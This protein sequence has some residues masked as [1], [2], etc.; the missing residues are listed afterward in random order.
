MLSNNYIQ[1][2]HI[3]ETEA[4]EL[5][6]D[7]EQF[8]LTESDLEATWVNQ[9]RHFKELGKERAQEVN[10]VA[11]VELLQQLRDIESVIIMYLN[12]L[13]TGLSL[14][15]PWN[16]LIQHS[17]FKSPKI[18]SSYHPIPHTPR[19]YPKLVVA[20]LERSETMSCGRSS[21]WRV[22]WMYSGNGPLWTLSTRWPS[23]MTECKYLQALENLHLLVMKQLFEMHNLNML[24]TGY[25]MRTDIAQAL[26]RR[27]KAT[28]NTVNK[29]NKHVLTSYETCGTTFSLYHELMNR[30][31]KI[32]NKEKLFASTLEHLRG[33]LMLGPVLEYV[34]HRR[35]VN[36][37]LI[38]RI[39][40][41]Y[42]LPGLTWTPYYDESINT[43]HA[44]YPHNPSASEMHE[45]NTSPPTSLD[46]NAS[47]S[48]I[49]HSTPDD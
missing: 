11:Y 41:T 20:F 31:H 14:E 32:V 18:L 2:L 47:R 33:L 4:A 7:L 46:H 5:A 44:T 19:G 22:R 17:A 13:L 30:V 36:K 45:P 48:N 43:V 10:D 26:Q 23:S 35:E 38:S 15:Q 42:N 21:R 27:A 29:Y 8:N 39:N 6:H 12:L 24:G 1:V 37:L 3:L 34:T 16:D 40:A 49:P 25:E 28:R 9:A